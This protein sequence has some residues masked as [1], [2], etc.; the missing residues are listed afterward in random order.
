VVNALGQVA[1]TDLDCLRHVTHARG[2]LIVQRPEAGLQGLLV[3]V[4]IQSCGDPVRDLVTA[5]VSSAYHGL[6][7]HSLVP[8]APSGMH[9]G[10]PAQ[11]I[12]DSCRA[13]ATTE[14]G[15]S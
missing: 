3:V 1:K 13:S 8:A 2:N 5:R 11:Q 14:S 7:A 6:P 15:L 9:L 10:R 12:K 4:L